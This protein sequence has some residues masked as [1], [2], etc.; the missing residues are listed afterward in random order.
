MTSQADDVPSHVHTATSHAITSSALIPVTSSGWNATA[1]QEI[2]N[3]FREELILKR[4]IR[5]AERVG[6]LL[7]S[8]PNKSFF[9]AFGAGE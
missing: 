8:N 4:N 7:R 6:R 5:M 3:Y 2:E 9:F 1:A